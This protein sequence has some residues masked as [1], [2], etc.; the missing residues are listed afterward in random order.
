MFR[1]YFK[2]WMTARKINAV[3]LSNLTGVSAS[4]I[5]SFLTNKRTMSNANLEK[6]MEALQ[7]TLVPIR[8]FEFGSV[9]FSNSQDE[10]GGT[11]D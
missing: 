3:S 2:K 1:E 10:A 8:D 4:T 11:E 6:I 5:S 9:D 7:I